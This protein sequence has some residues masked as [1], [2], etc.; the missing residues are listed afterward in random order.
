MREEGRSRGRG[1]PDITDRIHS[2]WTGSF[3]RTRQQK[4]KC[5][6]EERSSNELI[7]EEGGDFPRDGTRSSVPPTFAC[8]KFASIGWRRVAPSVDS[9]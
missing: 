5:M 4:K 1:V 3:S 2:L 6:I 7:E 8:A 9:M